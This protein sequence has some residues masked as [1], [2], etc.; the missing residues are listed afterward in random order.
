M[1]CLTDSAIEVDVAGRAVTAVRQHASLPFED[2]GGQSPASR[3]KWERKGKMAEK[4][5]AQGRPVL[6]HGDQPVPTIIC[7]SMSLMGL[8]MVFLLSSHWAARVT[9]CTCLHR[10]EVELGETR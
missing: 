6:H 2:A 3:M 10:G 4:A 8:L 7:S 9:Q 1:N 5:C